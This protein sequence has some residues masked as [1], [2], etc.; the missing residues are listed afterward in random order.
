MFFGQSRLQ[1]EAV[2]IGIQPH[3]IQRRAHGSQRIRAGTQG[4][5]VGRKLDRTGYPILA[6]ELV[7][8]LAG[9]IWPE[10]THAGHGKFTIVK[11]LHHS[12]SAFCSRSMSTFTPLG[13]LQPL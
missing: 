6:F 8:G 3:V 9:G 4:V 10:L 2:G 12:I 13:A 5:L 7:D 1:V 11:R